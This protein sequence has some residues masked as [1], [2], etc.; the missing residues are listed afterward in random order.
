M[1]TVLGRRPPPDSS[2]VRLPE[3]G[4]PGR[5]D[6]RHRG[7]EHRDVA[8]ENPR[9]GGRLHA[10]RRDHVWSAIGRRRRPVR[11]RCAGE[12]GVGSASRSRSHRRRPRA[13]R[14]RRRRA[15]EPRASSAVSRSVS[16]DIAHA[17]IRV[18]VGGT[19]YW[20][21]SR[22]GALAKLSSSGNRFG[23]SSSAQTLTTSRGCDVGGTLSRSSSETLETASRIASSSRR[24]PLELVVPQ[25]QAREPCDVQHLVSADRHPDRPSFQTERAPFGG[26]SI[27]ES[28]SSRP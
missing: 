21:S 23:R 9:P 11:R 20:S 26:P 22:E 4:Q 7:V 10:V 25:R 18:A 12:V 15:I 1:R 13:A 5:L 3:Q 19:R 2:R 17:S 14:P 6:T 24:Q 27:L 16:I 28:G 8:L